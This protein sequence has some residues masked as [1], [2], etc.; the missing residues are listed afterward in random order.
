[1]SHP[2]ERNPICFRQQIPSRMADV[3]SLCL[4]IRELL[5]Q[6][7]LSEV[8]FLVELLARECLNNARIHGNQHQADKS[9][10]FSLRIGREWI[11]L[12][13]ADEGTGFAW[14]KARKNRAVTNVPSGR[15]LQLCWLYADRVQFN[16]SGNQISLWISKKNRME[17]EGNK[18][19]AYAMEQENQDGTVKLTGDL[20]A[21]L[22]PE[23]QAGLMEML[24]KGARDV[25]FD[26]RSAEMLDSS[27]M[28]L[29][30]A[31]ANSLAPGGGRVRVTN[32]SPDIYRLLQSMRLTARLNVSL[33]PE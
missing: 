25:Q 22:V 6:N 3:D 31:T 32:V 30:I 24:K 9:I 1:M 11:R 23:L 14:R 10:E 21:V 33:R 15:G 26:L 18:M 17:E 29:L 7:G 19:A 13:I 5:Q 8:R 28:G 27:G 2:R 12:Q 4:R 20:T 16:R